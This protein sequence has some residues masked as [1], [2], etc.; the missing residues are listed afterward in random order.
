[1]RAGS[2]RQAGADA[3]AQAADLLG[4]LARRDE[5]IGARTTYRVGGCAALFVEVDGEEAL[6]RTARA[7]SESGVEVL[8]LGC[9][10]NLLVADSG[11][12]GCC[13]S[14]AGRFASVALDQWTGQIAAGG[15]AR[16]PVLARQAA[17]AGVAGMGWAVGI[18]GS[19]GGAARMNAGGHGCDTAARLRRCRVVDLA[20]ASD[21]VRDAAGLALGYR[22]SDLG[23]AELVVE[24]ELVGVPGAEP[25]ELAD[26]I[27]RI[28]AWR[29]AAQ[30]GGRNA[31]SVFTNPSGDS[32][33]RL[34]EA[35]GLKG[36]RIG[37]AAV[38]DKHAN[39]I[40]CDAEGSADDV[41]A[42]V[43]EVQHLVAA[44][45]GVELK[46]ELQMVGF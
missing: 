15:A 44:R 12:A 38:S 6:E 29:R 39:F 16:Y 37:T 5:P 43:L 41:A 30:P 40:Q 33:G 32:A 18:P 46:V 17:A 10:S 8:V 11:F 21:G 35:A 27:T 9:G 28:V 20:R 31:G 2:E 19:A 42:V 34:V 14:L 23:P 22:S 45:M 7:V 13:V 36:F 3:V 25:A 26:E 1:M 4:P 24:V